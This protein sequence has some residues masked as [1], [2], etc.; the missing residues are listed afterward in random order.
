MSWN[1]SLVVLVWVH[2]LLGMPLPGALAGQQP[3]VQLTIGGLCTQSASIA[4]E[5]FDHSGLDQ[6]LRTYVNHH[7]E[8]CYRVWARQ[9]QDL[10]RLRQYLHDL[11]HIDLSAPVSREVHLTLGINAY[12]AL[13]LHGILQEYPVAS[14][15]LLNRDTSDYKVFDDLKLWF[16]GQY[17]SLNQLEN[18]YLRPLHDPRIHFALV[19]AARGCPKL[20]AEAYRPETIDRQLS[21]NAVD[22]FAAKSHFRIVSLRHRVLLSPILKWYGEDFGKSPQDVLMTV[23]P[24]LPPHDQAWLSANPGWNMDF[25]GYDW[26]LNDQCPTPTVAFGRIPFDVVE[27]WEPIL[28]PVLPQQGSK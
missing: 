2:G 22:F 24:W 18:E 10:H 7:G 13:A 1:E 14:I 16:G 15:Q 21:E 9:P 25:L 6:L 26:G 27:H 23:Y 5:Q 3:P 8:V 28:R 20:R 17:V 11:G 12:N 19:C 4:P